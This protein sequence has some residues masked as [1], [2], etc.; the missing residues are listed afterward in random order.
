MKPS[1]LEAWLNS[2]RRRP[3]VMGVLNVTPDSFSD[4][5]LYLSPEDAAERVGQM[6][7][8]GA[9]WIDIGGE[10][11]RPGSEPVEA[12]EQWQRVGPAVTAAASA[13]VVVSIDTTN[14]EV[15]ERAM[16][17][18]ASIVN[19]VTAGRADPEMPGVMANA[20]AAVLMHMQGTPRDMQEAPAYD[21][22]VAEVSQH[23]QGR[24]AIVEA[25][26]LAPHR[27]LLDPGIG[28]GKTLHH[29]LELLAATSELAGLGHPLLVGTSRKR[30]IGA[31]TGQSR[32]DQR[33]FGT[34]ATVAW[35]V[36][37]GA[38]VMRV[39]DVRAMREVVDVT[40]SPKPIVSDTS[41]IHRCNG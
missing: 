24:V 4:G 1:E 5:G 23:L 34:A 26:G 20:Q 28:F 17:D 6:I 30:F 13:G 8:E 12:S 32:A 38:S 35:A 10:S 39:H 16:G 18:G 25:A 29:N 19:D 21:N 33:Q 15:A 37:N 31:L 41:W 11:T 36:A 22:V 9:D 27:I 3:L 2:P 7:D 40:V 14:A